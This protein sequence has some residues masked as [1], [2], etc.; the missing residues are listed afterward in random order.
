MASL[1]L[2]FDRMDMPITPAERPGRP[3][4]PPRGGASALVTDGQLALQL[5]RELPSLAIEPEWKDQQRL[6]GHSF[7]P[8]C[9]YLASFPAALVHAFIARYTRPGDVVLDQ[10]GKVCFLKVYPIKE[11]PDIDEIIAFLKNA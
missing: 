10:A 7:H 8:M 6:W 11:L 5:P 9:S 4:R 1:S 3:A 2:E